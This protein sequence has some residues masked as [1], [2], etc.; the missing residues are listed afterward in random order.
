MPGARRGDLPRLSVAPMM[1]RTDR[2]YRRMVRRIT[3]RTL[4]YSEMVTTGALLYGDVE[5]QLARAP[6]ESPVALQL[7]GDD[8]TALA[9]AA[10]LAEAYGY[11]EVDLN[12]GCPSDR[13]QRGGFGA[14]LMAAPELVAEAV[15]AMR[16]ACSLPVTVKHRLGI[17]DRDRFEDMLRFVEVVAEAG[18]DRFVV[19]AR[20]AWLHGLSPKENRTVPPL[21]HEEVYRLAAERPDLV[22]ETNGGVSGLGDAVEHA[23]FVDGVMIGR[24]AYEAPMRLVTADARFF[25]SCEPVPTLR[26][27]IDGVY[28]LVED[29]RARGTR[30]ATLVRALVGLARGVPGARGWRRAL[31]LGA[32]LPG[33]GPELIERAS[34]W[35]SGDVLDARAA[36]GPEP[37]W[38]TQAAAVAAGRT[39]TSASTD[40]PQSLAASPSLSANSMVPS[41]PT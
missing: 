5:R 8:P 1:D 26:E 36:V 31:T 6:E 2:V 13:V 24:A 32:P 39:V 38:R 21:R 20:K 15:A 11:D 35:L 37:R 34:T 22:V 14:C 12:V 28:E 29:E 19:H 23:P 4:L 16:G 18:A 30:M 25:G 41:D 27:V 33:A 9:Q 17:D 3:R 40:T 7:G 10:R